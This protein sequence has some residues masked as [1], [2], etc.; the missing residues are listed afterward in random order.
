MKKTT[1]TLLWLIQVISTVVFCALCVQ[2][3]GLIFFSVYHVIDP[4]NSRE[5]ILGIDMAQLFSLTKIDFVILYML[6]LSIPVLKAFAFYYTLKIFNR[7]NLV[8]PFSQEIASLISKISYLILTIGIL[9]TVAF[10]YS[11]ILDAK[12]FELNQ[13][14]NWWNDNYAYLLMGSI[15]F[16]IAQVFKKGLEIQSENELTV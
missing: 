7:L 12:G 10:Q 9:G 4:E 16:V 13:L 14:Q 8:K 15:I 1:N 5:M 2:A 6:T 11:E 3:A